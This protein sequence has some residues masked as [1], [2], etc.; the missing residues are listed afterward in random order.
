MCSKAAAMY[1]HDKQKIEDPIYSNVYVCNLYSIYC[2]HF[3][4]LYLNIRKPLCIS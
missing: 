2:F 3:F 1:T 4:L